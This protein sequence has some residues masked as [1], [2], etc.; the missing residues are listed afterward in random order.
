MVQNILYLYRSIC[1]SSSASSAFLY[2][3]RKAEQ[4]WFYHEH[5]HVQYIEIHAKQNKWWLQHSKEN[6]WQLQQ[7]A[8]NRCRYWIT[9]SCGHDLLQRK[10]YVIKICENVITKPVLI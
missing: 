1:F 5:T 6:K 3:E 4:I 2:H 8:V 9:M 7:W 10:L